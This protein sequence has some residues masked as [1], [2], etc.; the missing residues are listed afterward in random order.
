VRVILGGLAGP[1]EVKGLK[2]NGAMPGHLLSSDAEV[3]EIASFVRYAFG[4]ITENPIKPAEVKRLRPAVEKRKFMPW[5]AKELR[6]LDA[7]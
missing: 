6:E 3:A 7:H 2:F 1:I 5:T 4:E